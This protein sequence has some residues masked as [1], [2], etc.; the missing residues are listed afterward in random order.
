M[1]LVDQCDFIRTLFVSCTV[2]V[3]PHECHWVWFLRNHNVLGS[4]RGPLLL[5]P[6]D[7]VDNRRLVSFWYRFPFW[8]LIPR[9]CFCGAFII[10]RCETLTG[11]PLSARGSWEV[12][13]MV[14]PV[15]WL[16]SVYPRKVEWTRGC[17]SAGSLHS[18][19]RIHSENS[20]VGVV[21]LSTLPKLTKEKSSDPEVRCSV[22]HFTWL[23]K[24]NHRNIVYSYY[25]SFFKKRSK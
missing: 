5:V 19:A 22:C 2:K 16:I 17:F 25:H 1:A 18:N 3:N 21:T 13:A 6:T 7:D 23:R 20:A 24:R 11:L 9:A 12:M 4:I 8:E 10:R 14:F 15:Y